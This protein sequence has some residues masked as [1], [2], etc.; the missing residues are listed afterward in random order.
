MTGLPLTTWV[1]LAVWLAVGLLLYFAY[2]AGSAA[3]VRA[4]RG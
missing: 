1:R 2:G 3:R 4:G